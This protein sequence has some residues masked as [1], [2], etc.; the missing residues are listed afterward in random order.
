PHSVVGILNRQFGQWRG[1]AGKASFIERS[2][3]VNERPKR[4]TVSRDVVDIQEQC[5]VELIKTH[6]ECPHY[7]PRSQIKRPAGYF[8]HPLPRFRFAVL[9]RETGNINDR[10]LNR[11]LWGHDLNGSVVLQTVSSA[12]DFVPAYQS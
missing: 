9:R 5:M 7:R 2:E 6:E 10:K 8:Y 4:P 1:P 12:Q 11:E 3:L